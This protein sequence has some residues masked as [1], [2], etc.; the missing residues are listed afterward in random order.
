MHSKR[1]EERYGLMRR[2]EV[3]SGIKFGRSGKEWECN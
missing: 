2:K 1:K 3:S